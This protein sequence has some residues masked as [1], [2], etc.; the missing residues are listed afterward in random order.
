MNKR[1]IDVDR[2]RSATCNSD[3]AL[4]YSCGEAT[5]EE[6]W[7]MFATA[8]DNAPVREFKKAKWLHT[9]GTGFAYC[10]CC[11]DPVSFMWCLSNYCP[12]CGA[13]MQL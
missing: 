9:D 7:V 11:N 13:K 10:S 4:K 1:W 2:L 3:V 12:N 8:I 5:A 6:V